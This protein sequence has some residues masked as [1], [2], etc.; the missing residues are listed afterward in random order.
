MLMGGVC[1]KAYGWSPS[2]GWYA[3]EATAADC[4]D[5]PRPRRPPYERPEA[6][7]IVEKVGFQGTGRH[8]DHQ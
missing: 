6:A 7:D 5:R 3:D 4:R 1:A 2:K 8:F